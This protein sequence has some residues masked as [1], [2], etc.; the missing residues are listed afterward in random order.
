MGAWRCKG[1]A[2][3]ALALDIEVKS[4]KFRG[5]PVPRSGRETLA[6]AY[7]QWKELRA[8][9]LARKTLDTYEAVWD[10]HIKGRHDYHMLAEWV[11][12]PQLFEELTA[13]MRTRGVGNAAQRKVLVVMS[14]VFKAAAQWNKIGVN[15]VLAV[16]KPPG[17][18]DRIPHPFPPLVVERIRGMMIQR[19]TRGTLG[20]GLPDA[21]LVGLMAY[22]GLRPGEALALEWRDI[23]DRTITV[24][25]AVSL[26]EQGPTK[27]G[28]A[29]V[30]P[31]ASPLAA[32]LRALREK[33]YRPQDYQ[34][35]FPNHEDK[36]WSPSQYN[37]WRNRVW[38]KAMGAVSGINPSQPRLA[39][40]RPYD[41]RGSFVSLQLR[42]GASPL[43]VAQWAGH[44][45][46]IMFRHYAHVI[47]EL[48]GQP[49]V[50]AAEQIEHAR[51]AV[52]TLRRN[53]LDAL[54]SNLLQSPT[55][56]D[57]DREKAMQVVSRADN[58]SPLFPTS[59]VK[60]HRQPAS[61]PLRHVPPAVA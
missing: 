27:T 49:T 13:D 22:A 60:P 28:G 43:E 35:V 4:R 6:V 57:A 10:A 47:D 36:H 45:P 7:L 46:Q 29:R 1:G 30:V 12:N 44:S 54:M 58:F 41:C 52:S 14:S 3:T 11:S 9:L 38:K 23:G 53:L 34:L 59:E 21:C 40:A 16:V 25:K 18:R 42:A 2:C 50:P 56:S 8:P 61:P 17:T 51:R 20:G 5:E 48:V 31:L 39:K 26:G 37:N 32:D 24:D 15:P 19:Q 33:K 55:L